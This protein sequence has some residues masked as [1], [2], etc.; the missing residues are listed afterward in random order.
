MRRRYWL[1]LQLILCGAVF[2]T[3]FWWP[4][5]PLWSRPMNT[6]RIIGFMKN[7]SQV[8]VLHD[9]SDSTYIAY[10]V[11][12]GDELKRLRF[13]YQPG[14]QL[15]YVGI[16]P[17]TE[18]FIVGWK[19][20]VPAVFAFVPFMVCIQNPKV[21]QVIDP[22]TLESVAGPFPCSFSYASYA[23]SPDGKYF[24]SHR[25]GS[26]LDY[27][28]IEIYSGKLLFLAKQSSKR[29]TVHFG[30]FSPDSKS[31]AILWYNKATIDYAIEVLNLPTGKS[32]FQQTL[33]TMPGEPWGYL[34]E[35]TDRLY[36]YAVKRLNKDRTYPC[37]SIGVQ[38][39]GL[40]DLRL[41]PLLES[42]GYANEFYQ[43]VQMNNDRLFVFTYGS[44]SHFRLPQWVNELAMKWGINTTPS[45]HHSMALRTVDR[46]SG[47]TI[48]HLAA[49]DLVSLYVSLNRHRPRLASWHPYKGLLMWNSEPAARWPWAWGSALL[50]CL[51]LQYWRYRSFRK[52]AAQ[53][54]HAHPP[55]R[56]L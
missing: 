7:G 24:W 52:L 14:W 35:W 34:R 1:L 33:P 28:L 8:L 20:P 13:T 55:A 6:S 10:D 19:H 38:E 44:R 45:G 17:G 27:E 49:P 41:E 9:H 56:P 39:S 32:K 50:V 3:I 4:E 11:E 26:E 22:D 25:D 15:Q 48:A 46:Q 2:A 53:V 12:T 42:Q 43:H 54:T 21:Y 23:I 5:Q 40:V 51:L 29:R 30:N 36:L 31:V 18:Q 47:K 16:L 37:Y